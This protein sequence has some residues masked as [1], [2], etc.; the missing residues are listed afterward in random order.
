[1]LPEITQKVVLVLVLH[2]SLQI[3]SSLQ[4]YLSNIL[5]VFGFTG[6]NTDSPKNVAGVILGTYVAEATQ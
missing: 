6:G 1:M 3:Y 5:R 4:K 2:G